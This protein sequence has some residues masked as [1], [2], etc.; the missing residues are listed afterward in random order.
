MRVLVN[1]DLL[2]YKPLLPTYIQTVMYSIYKMYGWIIFYN[3]SVQH[4][5]TYAEMQIVVRKYIGEHLTLKFVDLEHHKKYFDVVCWVGWR[6]V[7]TFPFPVIV[8]AC[9]V[10]P[11]K[12]HIIVK[13]LSKY[14]DVL[15]NVWFYFLFVCFYLMVLKVFQRIPLLMNTILPWT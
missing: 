12:C 4:I 15:F 13:H 7:S 2:K 6:N 1:I 8:N 14:E 10:K 5:N 3:G 9:T 11:Q